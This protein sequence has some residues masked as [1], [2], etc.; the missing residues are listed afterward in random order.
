[1]NKAV[2]AFVAVALVA[3]TMAYRV[4]AMGGSLGGFEND[5]FVTL[6]QAQQMA[7]GDWPVR[8]F[9]SLG[10]PLTILLSALGQVALGPTLFSRGVAD[11]R[12]HRRLRRDHVPACVA[13][14]RVDSD[15]FG[16]GTRADC[17]GAA[18]STIS[19]SFSPMR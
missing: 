8:D 6:S 11:H 7:M 3:L 2:V 14:V 19:R 10:K 5:Q 9:V 4:L 18:L 13:R 15:R 16:G 1:M 17:N 12:H